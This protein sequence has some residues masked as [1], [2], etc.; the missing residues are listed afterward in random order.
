MIPLY[1]LPPPEEPQSRVLVTIAWVLACSS[2]SV[3]VRETQVDKV[4]MANAPS[5]HNALMGCG[6]MG[7]TGFQTIGSDPKPVMPY[8][9]DSL[10][11]KNLQSKQRMKENVKSLLYRTGRLTWFVIFGP[12]N[13]LASPSPWP[14]FLSL[15]Q[16]PG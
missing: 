16:D 13:A 15:S 8:R 14:P 9:W 10:P 4:L 6:S 5:H 12:L 1:P 7:L 11:S 3:I 2:S